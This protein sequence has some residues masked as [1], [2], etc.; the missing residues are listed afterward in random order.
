M[1]NSM[2]KR[3]LLGFG[4]VLLALSVMLVAWQG[5]LS[6]GQFDPKSLRQTFIFWATSVLIFVLMVTLGFLLFRELVKLYIARQSNRDGSRIR[7]K[8]VLGAL[9]LSCLPVFCLV[10]FSY[11]VLSHSLNRW[12]TNPVEQ[13]LTRYTDIAKL[14]DHEMQ[15]EVNAQAAL[16]AAK[17]ETLQLLTGGAPTPGFLEQ[18]AEME[19]AQVAAIFPASGE[20]PA[21][22]W[23]GTRTRAASRRIVK[24]RSPVN[25]GGKTIGYAELISPVPV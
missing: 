8:L 11:E 18:F 13:Q 14:L 25:A 23:S 19:D 3:L 12:F 2:K 10:L 4:G 15:D 22:S 1:A 9:T 24:A 17:P 20:T 5:S 21:D 6:L 7:T 16:L